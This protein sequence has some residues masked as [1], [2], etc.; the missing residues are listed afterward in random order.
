M[1]PLASDPKK[2]QPTR[3][4]I[5]DGLLTEPLSDL[6]SV[7]LVGSRCAHCGETTL[8]RNTI[9]PNCGQSAT[10]PLALNPRG[11]LW[12]YTIVR[13]R[14]P[15]DYKGPEPFAPFAM[16]L[17]ELP[18]GLRVLAP[19]DG[20]ATTLQIGMELQFRAYVRSGDGSPE[21]VTF[22][23]GPLDEERTHV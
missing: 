13:H 6:R 7:R 21:V 5:R 12:T 4:P 8:G 9:C 23:F 1:N 10:T 14:P 20:D 2:S 22:S 16:G 15:G 3:V 18:D 17:V 11:R 19:V